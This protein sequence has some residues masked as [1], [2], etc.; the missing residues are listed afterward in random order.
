MFAN[1]KR[2]VSSLNRYLQGVGPERARHPRRPRAGA[3]AG[4]ARRVQGRRG[5][6]P[7]R[8]RRGGARPRHLR[9]AGRD[10]F[11]RAASTPTTM[12]IGSAAPAA[13][14]R[15]GAP[16][17]MATAD[18]VKSVAAIERLI[19]KPIRRLEVPGVEVEPV[20]GRRRAA[21]AGAA[22]PRAAGQAAAC[23][24]R[25]RGGSATSS[26]RR[27]SPPRRRSRSSQL[28]PAGAKTGTRAAATR[29]ASTTCSGSR[30][31]QRRAGSRKP[32]PQR[33]SGDR[34]RRAHATLPA[35]PARWRRAK[36]KPAAADHLR[37]GQ[38][39]AGHAY[40][41]ATPRAAIGR[42]RGLL[43]LGQY[44]L[45]MKFHLDEATSAASSPRRCRPCRGEG[46]L[47]PDHLQGFT[48][49]RR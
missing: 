44:D 8:D 1:R 16:S 20:G 7:G 37:H 18:E 29:T 42:F 36:A 41:V 23:R 34:V 21:A 4:D 2:E 14:A 28:P 40:E 48:G 39:R 25:S 35:A 13:P 17:R 43:D 22:D 24:R 10:Q 11:R 3:P 30:P 6:L 5:R 47:H 27:L 33:G 32:E 12:S 49:G 9:H 46:H 26:C 19:G 38:V 31:A 45:I 15:A